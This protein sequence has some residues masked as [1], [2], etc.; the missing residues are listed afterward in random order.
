[1]HN[2]R[3][4]STQATSDIVFSQDLFRGTRSIK[5][6]ICDPEIESEYT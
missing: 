1:M 2:I 5:N 3:K 6:G 4:F